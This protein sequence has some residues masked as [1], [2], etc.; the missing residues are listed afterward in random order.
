MLPGEEDAGVVDQQ[1][2]AAKMVDG[3]L[4][5]RDGGFLIADVTVDEH[6]IGR[7]FEPLGPTDRPSRADDP[8]PGP[9]LRTN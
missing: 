4:R 3:R 6:E 5:H 7:D 2:D 8:R 9:V 1:V